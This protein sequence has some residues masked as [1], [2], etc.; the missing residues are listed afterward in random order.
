MTQT[1]ISAL[2]ALANAVEIA[3]G[4]ANFVR[5]PDTPVDATA[6]GIVLMNDGIPGEPEPIL[7]PASYSFEHQV[8]FEIAAHGETRRAACDAR[9]TQ[10]EAA[11]A[12]DRTLGGTVDDARI[13]SGPDIAETPMDGAATERSVIVT[14]TLCY[15]TAKAS[16]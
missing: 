10:I 8:P 5:D 11:L 7:S 6:D 13:V 4:S 2:D 15:T 14:V 1:R 9:I 3:V 16:G 12:A